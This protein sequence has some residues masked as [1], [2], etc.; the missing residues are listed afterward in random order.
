MAT[1]VLTAAA[2]AVAGATGAGAVATFA[3]TAA[4]TVAGTYLDN[5]LVSAF[6]PGSKSHVEGQRLENLQVMGS[7]E[8]A[9]VPFVVGRARV[10]GQVIWATNLHEVVSTKTQ[11]HGGKSG[12]G[13]SS[14]V[15]QTTYSYFANFAVGLCEGPIS[16]ILRVWADGKEVDTSKITMRVYKGDEAQEADPLIAAKQGSADAPAYRGL[17]YVVFEELPLAAYGNRLPQMSFEVVRAV[18]YEEERLPAVAL[19]PGATEFGYSKTPVKDSRGGPTTAYNNRHTLCAKT[20]WEHSLDLLQS[21]CPACKRV[22]LV[23][24]WFGDDL[25]AGECTIAPRVEARKRTTPIEWQVAG[26]SRGA[27]RLVSYVEGKPA[28]GGSPSDSVVIEAIQDLKARGLEVMLCPFVMMDIAR[29][30]GLPDPYGAAEQNAYPWRGRITCH[31]AAGQPDSVDKSAAAAVQVARFMGSAKAADFTG[32]DGFDSFD[33]SADGFEGEAEGSNASSGEWRYARFV[34]HMANLARRAG[35]VEAFV[36]GSE[37]VGLTRVRGAGGDYPFVE[38]LKSLASEARALLGPACKIGYG[39]DWSE[40]HSHQTIEGDLV[41]H[42]DPLWAHEDIDFIGIDN[43]LPLTDWRDQEAHA[44]HGQGTQ[45]IHDLNY[46]KA[47]IEGGEYYDWYYAS[48]EDRLNQTRTP[49]ADL[50]HGEHWIYRQKD[51]RG[52]WQNPHHNHRKGVRQSTPTD[53]VPMSKPIWFTEFGCPA[54]D[55]GAN[56]P[57]VFYD[58]KSAESEVPYFSSGA[59]DD[60]IQRR[61]LRA[62]LDYWQPQAGHNPVSPVYNGPMVDAAHMYAW[63]WDVRPFPSFPVESDTWADW[64]NFTTGH[65]LSGRVGGV[66]VDG[67]ARLLM[68]RAGLREGIDFITGGADGVA[69]GFLISSIASARSVLETL[70]AA[71]FFD[72]VETGGRVAFCPRRSRYPLAEIAAEQLVDQGKGK[73]RVAITRA[74]ETELPAVVRVTAYDS[75]KDFN[76]VT[77]E[78]LEGAVSTQRVVTTDLP[79]V[80]SFDRLQSMAESLLQEAWASRE[81]LSFVLPPTDLQIEPGDYL[82]LSL[83]GRTFAVRVLSV[84]DG[85]ARMIEAVS[86]DGPVYEA[87]KGAARAFVSQGQALQAAPVAVF[88]DGPLLRDQDTAWQGYLSGYQLPFAPGMAF[89][90]SPVTSGYELRAALD[91]Q[92][93]LGELRAPLPAGPLYR[94]DSCNRVELKLYSGALASLPEDLVFAGGNAL[95]IE[96]AG[97]EWELLQFATAEL[98][99]PRTYTLSKLLRGQRGSEPGMG[100]PAGARV[101]VLEGGITQNGLSRAE[102]GLPLN[103]RAGKAGA[104]AGSDDYTG[105]RKTFSGKGE[106]P[107]APVHLS[108]Q[109]LAGGTLVLRWIRRTRTGGD[110]WE[111]AEVPLGEA[112]EAYSIEIHQGGVLKR[113]FSVSGEAAAKGSVAYTLA[114]QTEDFGGPAPAFA[115]KVAQ[116]SQSYGT[117]VRATG[118]YVP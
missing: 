14:T 49:I 30:N 103:W 99:G 8:G 50:A 42:L 88:I 25:R 59:R 90:S 3:L 36:I 93:I 67:F 48:E 7:S 83:S 5:M 27:A 114:Q 84:K 104:A 35:G 98:T 47:G 82:K 118:A 28:Y 105:Y 116:L 101:V 43:Y 16:E 74:Q 31:P 65:W 55:K 108:A 69:D 34:L 113:S 80:T 19:I 77:A 110:S 54:I 117:G 41:F 96:G 102:L 107:L 45:S 17:A 61:Y 70:G 23:V 106:R 92:G 97:G 11:K 38:G 22:S 60:L 58:P 64:G 18:G 57:N 66:C 95:L 46:L 1:L 63:A 62:M 115:F 44:D 4:A 86:Y 78:A 20:D 100:A 89:L 81:R 111:V 9:V 39:A 13:R 21:T 91:R 26:L 56:Q 68:E 71:F 52:W 51:L 73:E 87:T 112:S 40:Y 94:W 6:T 32:S 15:T 53:W 79:V 29:D 75:A 24:A 12:G 109:R 33:S 85:E 76:L 37:M 10:A 72:A 2:S